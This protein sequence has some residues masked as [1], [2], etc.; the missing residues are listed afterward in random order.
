MDKK[1]DDLFKY[2]DNITETNKVKK[3][4][5]TIFKIL[6]F[7]ISIISIGLLVSSG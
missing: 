6:S 5:N 7:F 1:F 3:K 2:I 4:K